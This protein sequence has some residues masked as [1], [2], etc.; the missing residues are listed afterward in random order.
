M[1]LV[2]LQAAARGVPKPF[3]VRRSHQTDLGQTVRQTLHRHRTVARNRQAR[4]FGR[5]LLG[6][7][8]DRLG[9]LEIT[10]HQMVLIG[11][12][13]VLTGHRQRHRVAL[14]GLEIDDDLAIEGIDP[15]HAAEAPGLAADIDARTQR[16]QH[17]QT[18]HNRRRN[19]RVQPDRINE[20]LLFRR[21]RAATHDLAHLRQIDPRQLGAVRRIESHAIHR[22]GE[23]LLADHD[24]RQRG[25]RTDRALGV[26]PE[27]LSDKLQRG[28]NVDVVRV[29]QG[30]NLH[31]ESDFV[32]KNSSD[33]W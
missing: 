7:R 19:R 12:F 11:D 28:R 4:Q 16:H 32:H 27:L 23:Q 15:L 21:R 30:L 5:M 29:Q 2:G 33:V 14:L 10:G 26:L 18:L 6:H 22:P 17:T 3:P 25:K 31:S 13:K 20:E 9:I 1:G 24:L 8:R